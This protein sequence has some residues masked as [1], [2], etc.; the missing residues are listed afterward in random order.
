MIKYA[1][2]LKEVYV[3]L[4]TLNKEDYNKIPSITIQAIEENMNNDYKYELDQNKEL[5]E[6]SMMEGTKEILFNIFRDY[7]ATDEQR[8]KIKKIQMEDRMKLEKEKQKLY[9]NDIYISKSREL[10][11]VKNINEKL[12]Q[13]AQII[14]YK[15]NIFIKIVKYIKN[16][17]RR[18]K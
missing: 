8:E 16:I 7:L 17:F 11:N 5:Q 3:I 14:E 2:E 9:N 12:N 18:K 4:N 10:K 15:E 13:N 1:N 6:N